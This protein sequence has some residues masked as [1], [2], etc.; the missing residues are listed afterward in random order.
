M[1]VMTK[2]YSGL[3]LILGITIAIV[4][5]ALIHPDNEAFIITLTLLTTAASIAT[6]AVVRSHIK[7][8]LTSVN[9]VTNSI[10]SNESYKTTSYAHANELCDFY[11]NCSLISEK[12]DRVDGFI[13]AIQNGQLDEVLRKDNCDGSENDRLSLTIHSLCD[14]I[15]KIT[16]GVKQLRA[17]SDQVRLS[18]DQLNDGSQQQSAAVRT[19]SA[20]IEQ[21]SSNIQQSA[22]NASQTEKIADQSAGEAQL[23]GDAVA[24]AITAMKSIAEKISIVQEIARQTDLLALNAAVEAARAG[25]H[26]KGF[27]VVASEVR[28][29]AE[30]SQ[31][32]AAEISELSATTVEI[33]G[34]AGNML[35]TLVP[36]IQKTASLVR[37][38]ALS[39]NEQSVGTSQITSA[40][41]DLEVAIN[42]NN[43]ASG[44]TLAHLDRII[45]NTK[46]LHTATQHFNSR[47][48]NSDTTDRPSAEKT[49]DA[50]SM[51]EKDNTQPLLPDTGIASPKKNVDGKHEGP[52]SVS[53]SK[54]FVSAEDHTVD[55]GFSLDLSDA[56]ISDDDFQAY[57]G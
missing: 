13:N 6:G 47:R 31:H 52:A 1:S 19:A 27:A 20:A 56:D 37:E 38:I 53:S 42:N 41:S 54:P 46:A 23:S 33:S 34:T 28:K 39:A 51:T 25:E 36:N 8:L 40:I 12:F 17:L 30:R 22:E 14:Q 44:I 32:A 57:R 4:A 5:T 48:A 15:A 29:L 24:K 50:S 43:S 45:A 18:S 2:L 55:E 16:A 35:D 9:N 26:G 11:D 49:S 7:R 21:I 10:A 3:T